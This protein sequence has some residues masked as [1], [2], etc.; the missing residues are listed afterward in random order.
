M[1]YARADHVHPHDDTK[2]DKSGG[3]MTG[4]LVLNGDPVENLEAV[5]KQYVD[6]HSVSAMVW[7]IQ[8]PT[9]PTTPIAD[10]EEIPYTWEEINTITLAGKAQEYFSLGATKL[11]NLSTAVLGANAAIMMIIGFN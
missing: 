4:S 1:L 7:E 9:K 10:G 3:T 6:N 2:L 11:V 5:T 8:L